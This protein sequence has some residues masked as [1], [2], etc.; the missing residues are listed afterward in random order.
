MPWN[1]VVLSFP[2]FP[3]MYAAWMLITLFRAAHRMSHSC[4]K[5][6]HPIL[7]HPVPLGPILILSCLVPSLTTVS[8]LQ[9]SSKKPRMKFFHM[10]HMLNLSYPSRL[11]DPGDMW[12]EVHIM[13]ILVTLFSQASFHFLSM[14]PR[15]L[16]QRPVFDDPQA[17]FFSWREVPVLTSVHNDIHYYRAAYCNSGTRRNSKIILSRLVRIILLSGFQIRLFGA[18]DQRKK[19]TPSYLNSWSKQFV[20]F[21]KIILVVMF[22]VKTEY[23][24]QLRQTVSVFSIHA[25]C[26][27]RTHSPQTL[28]T[29]YQ[30]SK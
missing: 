12:W 20:S 7:F 21:C 23:S 1:S 6:T 22:R 15:R 8:F 17:V 9:C 16:S 19:S 10:C 13:M 24:C 18:R 14:T 5:W 30:K 29:W 2:Q 27:S 4:S 25:T 3:I 26:L 11:F 28:N